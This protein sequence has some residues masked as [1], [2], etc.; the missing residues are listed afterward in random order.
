MP[1]ERPVYLTRMNDAMMVDTAGA[2]DSTRYLDGK[3]SLWHSFTRLGIAN[4]PNSI[5]SDVAWGFSWQAGEILQC[6]HGNLV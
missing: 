3:D 1:T 5:P 4:L 6:M 2:T